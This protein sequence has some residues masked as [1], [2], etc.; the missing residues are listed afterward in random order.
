MK[1]TY[2]SVADALYIYLNPR[3]KVTK[4]EIVGEGVNVDYAGKEVIGI[5][6]LDASERFSEKELESI[7]FEV[8]TYRVRA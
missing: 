7:T 5:E 1:V 4:T 6:V 8:P 2:D 3:K